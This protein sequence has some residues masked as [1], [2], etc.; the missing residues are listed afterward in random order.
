MTVH[1]RAY[2]LIDQ[3][4]EDDVQA[5][6]QVMIRLLPTVKEEKKETL[7]DSLSPKMKAFMRMEQLRK[8]SAQY[9][10]SEAQRAK[11]MEEK[12]GAAI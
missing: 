8:I 2:S 4:S 11:A 9:D 5:V 6:I 1:E 12:Y 10:I 7:S 3:L